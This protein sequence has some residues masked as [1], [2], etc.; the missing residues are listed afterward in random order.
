[1]AGA[2]DRAPAAGPKMVVSQGGQFGLGAAAPE[3]LNLGTRQQHVSSSSPTVE[4]S[5]EGPNANGQFQCFLSYSL[6][7]RTAPS[8]SI[9]SRATSQKFHGR[10]ATRRSLLCMRLSRP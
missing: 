4:N 3:G 8:C 9:V 10:I 5:R 7:F 2:P 1:M 6:H